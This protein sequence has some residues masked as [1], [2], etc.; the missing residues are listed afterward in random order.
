MCC[1]DTRLS[2]WYCPR[3]LGVLEY[4]LKASL[5]RLGPAGC[6]FVPVADL[7]IQWKQSG[8]CQALA[9]F[10]SPYQEVWLFEKPLWLTWGCMQVL[11]CLLAFSVWW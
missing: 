5:S 2:L 11:T 4:A 6:L 1:I 10:I 7:P 3:S 9:G 8:F